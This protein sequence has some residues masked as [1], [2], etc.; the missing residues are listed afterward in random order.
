M[1]EEAGEVEI[2]LQESSLSQNIGETGDLRVTVTT[3]VYK[4]KLYGC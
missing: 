1:V 4:K 3:P 2:E